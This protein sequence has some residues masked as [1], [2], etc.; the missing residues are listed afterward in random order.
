MLH[1]LGDHDAAGLFVYQ[2]ISQAAQQ[3]MSAKP[4]TVARWVFPAE[5]KEFFLNRAVPLP[6]ADEQENVKKIHYGQ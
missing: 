5:S 4:P 3:R 2:Y 1:P 6:L